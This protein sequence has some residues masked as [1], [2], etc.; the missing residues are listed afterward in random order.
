MAVVVG[1][2][3]GWVVRRREAH[4]RRLEEVLLERLGDGCSV[5]LHQRDQLGELY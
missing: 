5:R 1:W 3:G 2:A 4:L